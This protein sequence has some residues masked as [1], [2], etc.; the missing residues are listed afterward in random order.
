MATKSSSSRNARMLLFIPAIFLVAL[1]IVFFKSFDFGPRDVLPSA[2]VGKPFPEFSYSELHNGQQ[3]TRS[4]LIGE[5][6]LVNVWASWC[7]AC[8]V[9]HPILLEIATSGVSIVGLNYKDEPD[10]A[11]QWLL[12]R[13]NPYDF[14]IV[15]REGLLGIELGVTGA[16]ETFVLD[17][18]GTIVDK[19]VGLI[20]EATWE[21]FKS[22]YF[23]S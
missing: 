8:G 6:R 2:L 3:L 18:H 4:D 23:S 12:E 11:R 19:H 16:P 14:N 17:E 20:S 15:D 1:A 5:P 21:T 9:E 7:V 22:Q 10:T 13:G